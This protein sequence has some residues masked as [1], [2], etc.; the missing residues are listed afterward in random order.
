MQKTFTIFTV[1][2]GI[3]LGITTWQAEA[4]F[5]ADEFDYGSRFKL[6][7]GQQ[8]EIWNPFVTYYVN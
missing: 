2:L 1:A 6:T 5:R 7:D 4:Q 3:L 8:P